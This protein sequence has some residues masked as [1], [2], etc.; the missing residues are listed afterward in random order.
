MWP[1]SGWSWLRMGN[2]R[3]WWWRWIFELK[4]LTQQN[5]YSLLISLQV[6]YTD[7]D[8]RVFTDGARHVWEGRSPYDRHTYRSHLFCNVCCLSCDIV[9]IGTPPFWRI[10]WFLTCGVQAWGNWS[11]SCLTYLLAIF[12]IVSSG[13][14]F[15]FQEYASNH[16][17]KYATPQLINA[18]KNQLFPR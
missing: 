11:L 13:A 18:L 6:K 1:P 15:I 17:F 9:I 7:V 8:Y 5:F 10:W 12:S 2:S 4:N 3:T 16:S 14:E